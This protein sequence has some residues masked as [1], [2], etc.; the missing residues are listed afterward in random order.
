MLL[1][2]DLLIRKKKS[3]IPDACK[4]PAPFDVSQFGWKEERDLKKTKNR[5]VWI[6]RKEAFSKE[7]WPLVVAKIELDLHLARHKQLFPACAHVLLHSQL[8]PFLSSRSS[9]LLLKPLRMTPKIIEKPAQ[10]STKLQ[11]CFSR[12]AW[13]K[14]GRDIEEDAEKE[15][16]RGEVF[17]GGLSCSLIW[18]FDFL[19][20]GVKQLKRASLYYKACDI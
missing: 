6:W 20:C 11:T 15:K 18:Q 12:K 2:N 17:F 9:S 1:S 3:L 7:T 14:G 4:V 16:W 13:E 8:P 10:S 19:G 5:C